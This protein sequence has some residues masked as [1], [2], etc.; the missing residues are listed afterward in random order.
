MQLPD[1]RLPIA[2][3]LS[4]VIGAVVALL[5]L[6]STVVRRARASAEARA[7]VRARAEVEG[8]RLEA[9]LEVQRAAAAYVQYTSVRSELVEEIKKLRGR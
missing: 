8:E 7:A 4:A 9:R 2:L 3:A 5:A 6:W 1:D